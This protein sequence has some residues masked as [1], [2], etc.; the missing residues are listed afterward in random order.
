MILVKGLR[1]WFVSNVPVAGV[2]KR[3]V[4]A[5]IDSARLVKETY[6]Q[7]REDSYALEM[8]ESFDLSRGIYVDVGA[9]HPTRISNTYLFYRMGRR[10][11]VVEPNSELAELHRIYRPGDEVIGVGCGRVA[12]LG[13][14]EFC[15]APVL[16]R[17]VAQETAADAKVSAPWRRG[18]L[19]ILPL[20]SI[21]GVFDPEW[22]FFLSID[23][24]G[25]DLD[26]LVGAPET[27]AKSLLICVEANQEQEKGELVALLQSKRFKLH[28]ALG[29]NLL[30]V[31]Q[32][33]RFDGYRISDNS[34][35]V[36]D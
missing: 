9:N 28:H 23:V 6:A 10:G 20:D 1:E 15:K 35:V 18:Y 33:K 29:C 36:S 30:F 32:D 7:H 19:P 22:I 11:I 34:M 2:M 4:V 12:G 13:V 5:F 14:F 17:F 25:M 8:L 16:S 26:V 3:R 21:V 31:N 24:E 27:L